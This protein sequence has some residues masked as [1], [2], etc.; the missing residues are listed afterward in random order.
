MSSKAKNKKAGVPKPS[1]P[2][3]LE[4]SHNGYR[5]LSIT[6]SN[7]NS[8]VYGSSGDL[9]SYI[10]YKP[11]F[12]A[13]KEMSEDDAEILQRTIVVIGIPTHYSAD[14]LQE[15]FE[16]FG[17]VESSYFRDETSMLNFHCMLMFFL[18]FPTIIFMLFIYTCFVLLQQPQ[19]VSLQR[20]SLKVTKVMNVP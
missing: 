12:N 2:V 17:P 8:K 20:L 14:D 19:A 9:K 15:M 10:Y 4:V 1:A 16:M 5:S 3:T 6:T 13:K 18:L 7:Q 11:A